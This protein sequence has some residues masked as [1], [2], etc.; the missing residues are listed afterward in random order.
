MQSASSPCESPELTYPLHQP[1]R[2]FS[3]QN[4]VIEEEIT[5]EI[6]T[7]SSIRSTASFSSNE[8]EKMS[9]SSESYNREVCETSV[10]PSVD[11]FYDESNDGSRSDVSNSADCSPV[12][13]EN[14]VVN[15]IRY[16]MKDYENNRVSRDLQDVMYSKQPTQAIC[17]HSDET[18]DIERES[19]VILEGR[20]ILA[21]GILETRGM[22]VK[23]VLERISLNWFHKTYLNLYENKA[24]WRKMFWERFLF[25]LI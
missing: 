13:S 3:L 1:Y 2:N 25:N 14:G 23:G 16:V 18:L 11:H 24:N 8:E 21:G 22:S 4:E 12:H 6:A 9:Q 17:W 7:P 20:E 10:L 19:P 5:D 15:N